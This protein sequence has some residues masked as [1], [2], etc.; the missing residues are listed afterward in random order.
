MFPECGQA[1]HRDPLPARGHEL[2]H[3]YETI[4]R[5]LKIDDFLCHFLLGHVPRNISEGYVARAMLMA[6]EGMREAQRRISRRIVSLLGLAD[7]V[8]VGI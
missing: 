5:D 6:G 1:G 3:T 8:S 4:A 2:R 7:T